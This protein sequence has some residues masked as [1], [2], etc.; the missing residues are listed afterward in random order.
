MADDFDPYYQWL[1]IPPKH[2][3]PHHYRL[4][5]VELFE[6]NP[7]VISMAADQRMAHVRSFQTGKRSPQS[8]KILN[9]LSTARRCLLNAKAKVD[10]DAQLQASLAAEAP[11]AAGAKPTDERWTKDLA[12]DVKAASRFA[13]CQAER[14]KIASLKL[15]AAY[16]ALGSDI[17]NDGLLKEDFGG[18]YALLAAAGDQLEQTKDGSRA[19]GGLASKMV[20]ACSW[21]PL[22]ASSTLCS[23]NWAKPC[24]SSMREPGPRGRCCRRFRSSKPGSAN[25]TRNS[26]PSN[27]PAPA[28]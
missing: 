26:A 6:V 3:P 13:T 8:Q 12:A 16:A 2:Q 22:S 1:G 28:G 18:L 27:N 4:L 23:A 25:S 7:D 11:A 19:Q 21:T 15:P 10:Y 24:T 9:E 20:C 17:Y 5:G 14:L